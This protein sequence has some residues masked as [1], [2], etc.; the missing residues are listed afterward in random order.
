MGESARSNAGQQR[1][2][3]LQHANRVRLARAEMKRLIKRGQLSAAEVV[4]ECPWETY[5]MPVSEVL[6]SQRR[7]GT[8]RCRRVLVA[9]G[10]PENKTVGTLTDRQREA[11][12]AM[13]GGLSGNSKGGLE[14]RSGGGPKG[15][16][17]AARHVSGPQAPPARP[18]RP[19]SRERAL[20]A[21]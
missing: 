6:I 21:V 11:L 20:S 9:I 17:P 10:I 12:V 18:G 5:K 13:L 16:A 1:F 8:Q 7:W 4:A 14:E 15:P 3:A 2:T 19:G